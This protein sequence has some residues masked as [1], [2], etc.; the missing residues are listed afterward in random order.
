MSAL[1]LILAVVIVTAVACALVAPLRVPDEWDD[2]IAE[3]ERRVDALRP[4]NLGDAT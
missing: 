1:V 3:H 2:A 4:T